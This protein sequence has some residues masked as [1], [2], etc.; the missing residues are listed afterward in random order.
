ML[1]GFDY[2]VTDEDALLHRLR[3]TREGMLE[4]ASGVR[5]RALASPV[6]RRFSLAALKFVRRYLDAG[7]TVIGL[8]PTGPSGLVS[9]ATSSEWQRVASDIWGTDCREGARLQR[10]AGQVLCTAS[11]R[12]ALLKIGVLP[13]VEISPAPPAGSVAKS[14]ADFDYVHRK[15]G[16]R[17][18][19][20]VRNGSAH[21]SEHQ[22]VFRARANHVELWD[23]VDGSITDAHSTRTTDGRTT[24][25]LSL[26]PFASTFVV[27]SP[28]GTTGAAPEM[29]VANVTPLQ[30]AWQISFQNGRG[31]PDQPLAIHDLKSWTEWPQPGVKYF[32][33]TATYRAT[34]NPPAVHAGQQL[35]LRFTDVREIA[36]VRI[37]G[38]DAGAVWANPLQLRVDPWLHPGSNLLEIEVTNLWPNRIIG[39]LQ[40]GAKQRITRTNIRSYR[41][42][43]PLL[44]SGLIGAVSW[45]TTTSR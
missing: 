42:D 4:S 19:Y 40:P 34:V 6:Q 23:P 27:F 16:P 5:W 22:A 26:A 32:A 9:G 21:L 8:P 1:P 30:T 37:N 36:R 3:I 15:D 45:V 11:A 41:A 12:E 31:A 2:D 17:D 14:D 25:D 13:D 24:L 38:H 7:G 10:G 20:F 35:L 29:H 28:E 39:D 44:P 33:G 18:I 43:S